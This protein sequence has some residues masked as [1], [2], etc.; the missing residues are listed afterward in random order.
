MPSVDIYYHFLPPDDV[1]SARHLGDLATG[2]KE[3][4]WKVRAFAS[5]R[6]CRADGASYPLNDVLHE[7]EYIRTWRPDFSQNGAFGRIANA[8]WMFVSWAM[9]PAIDSPPDIVITGTDPI[10]SVGASLPWKWTFKDTKLVHWCF[11]LY[12]DAMFSE[13]MIREN[14]LVGKCL[15]T[16]AQAFLSRQDLIANLGPCMA[17][18]VSAQS[19]AVPQVTLTPWALVEPETPPVPDSRIRTQLFGEAKI[20]LLYSGSFGRAH[21]FE[22]ILALARSVRNQSIGFCFAVRGNRV[23]QLKA[24]IKPE[25]TNIRFAGFASE[26]ELEARLAAADIHI[27][28]LRPEWTGCVVPSKFFGS[29]AIGRPVLFSGDPGSALANTINQ[30]GMGWVLTENNTSEIAAELINLTRF[31]DPLKEI[32]AKCFSVYKKE[33]S[34]KAVIDRWDYNLR[35]I[36]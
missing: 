19:P 34:K 8:A 35:N 7:I 20:G 22:D 5:N 17:E 31:P 21:G 23:N 36:I 27:A 16:A 15:K 14:S 1:V 12:P 6:S 2:L 28:S 10:L 29:L 9:R 25:D 4:G 11:D 13:G 32:K 18:R 33:Y 24:A 26:E 30:F 3:R